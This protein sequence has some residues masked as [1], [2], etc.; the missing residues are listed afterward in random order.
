MVSARCFPPE[1]P[2]SSIGQWSE[3]VFGRAELGDRRRTL[4]LVQLAES[5]AARPAGKITEVC[6]SGAD[7]QGAYDLINNPQVTT[8]ALLDSVRQGTIRR[9]QGEGHVFVAVD[10][11]SL[12]I[13]DRKREKNFG[14]IGA[15][16]LGARG[17]KVINALAMGP[18][19][20]PLGLSSQRWWVRKAHKRR[21]DCHRRPVEEKETQHW[22]DAISETATGLSASGTLAWFLLDREGDRYATLLALRASGQAFTVRSTYGHRYLEGERRNVRLRHVVA[23]APLRLEYTLSLPRRYNRQSRE[24]RMQVRT[25]QVTLRMLNP[26]TKKSEPFTVNVVDANE[27]G[28][29]PQGQAPVHWRLFTNQAIKTIAN[30]VDV[31][32]SYRHRWKVEEFHRTWKSGACRVEETQLR[33]AQGVMKWSIIMAAVASRIER[34]KFLARNDAE[35][36]ADVEFTQAEI[37][38]TLL[39]KR[40]SDPAMS[41][42]HDKSPSIA[43]LTQ[44]IAELGGYTGRSSGGPPG[45]TTIRRGLQLI[46]PLAEGLDQL[47]IENGM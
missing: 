19:G 9:C 32:E 11:T 46:R 15:L 4:R 7:R 3:D 6:Q 30:V 21:R 35:R 20:T 24:A 36:P 28:R 14:A 16:S 39:L 12:N 45:T 34:I 47:R 17:L 38:A 13:T 27:I 25:T 42:K 22:L 5:A 40:R 33:T 23:R 44:L 31:L 37:Q 8:S 43:R 26:L 29:R 1:M 2:D 10:G 41:K 18:D